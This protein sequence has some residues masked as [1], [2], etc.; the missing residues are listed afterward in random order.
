M[1]FWERDFADATI[2]V[3]SPRVAVTLE[4]GIYGVR[5]LGQVCVKENCGKE[6]VIRPVGKYG[7]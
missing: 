7:L 2:N 3:T 6:L 4:I 5:K 1:L